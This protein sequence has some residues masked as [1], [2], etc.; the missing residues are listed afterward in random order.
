MTSAASELNPVLRGW[1]RCFCKGAVRTLFASLDQW[2][3]MR[4]RSFVHKRKVQERADENLRNERL[5]TAGLVS[6]VSL[7]PWTAR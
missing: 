3:R 7:L 2:V 5:A 1:G 4:I 6:L